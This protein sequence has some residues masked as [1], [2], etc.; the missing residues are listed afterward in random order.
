MDNPPGMET[1]NDDELLLAFQEEIERLAAHEQ[2]SSHLREI[3]CR[4]LDSEDMK[5]WEQYKELV[6]DRDVIDIISRADEMIPK[7]KL[8]DSTDPKIASQN[9][10]R[11][12][13]KGRLTIIK[14]QAEAQKEGA[15]KLGEFE[16]FMNERE[17][18]IKV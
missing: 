10:L 13:I 1:E 6:I 18:E 12:F 4:L 3:D 16:T 17:N 5:R 15:L 9:K 11:S 14:I 7:N 8:T 2:K